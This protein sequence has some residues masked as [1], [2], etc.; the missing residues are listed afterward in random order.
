[1][2]SSSDSSYASNSSST[3]S[4]SLNGN[5][6]KPH[7]ANQAAWQ[8]MNHLRQQHGQVGLDQFRLLY[9]V[10]SGSFGTVYACKIKKPV[11]M[12][13]PDDCIY[14]MKV[15]DTQAQKANAK[16]RVD[17]EKEI[18]R[19]V[20]HPFLPTLYAEFDVSHYSCF[21]MEY[22]PRGDLHH[23]VIN[24]Q[25]AFVFSI[26][27]AK[28]YAAEVLIALEY[29]HAMGIIYRDLK[30]ENVLVQEDGHIMLSD[31]DLSF[32]CDVVP[33][34]LH[35]NLQ[36]EDTDKTMIKSMS[37]FSSILSHKYKE[38]KK[39]KTTQVRLEDSGIEFWAEPITC[40]SSSFVGT[41]EYLAPEMI[42][43]LGYG[44]EV[45]WWAFGVFLYELLYGK[46]PFKGK[47]NK[48]TLKNILKQPLMFPEE[49][50]QY[51]D[52]EMK[53][54]NDL[55]RKLLVKNPKKRMGSFWGAV[56]IKKHVFFRGVEWSLIRS[57]KP[58]I[59]RSR[60]NVTKL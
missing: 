34:L 30:P 9:P 58:P 20:D 28:F 56:E 35:C 57:V 47:N 59:L 53:N 22:C 6:R 32:K 46:T 1:M 43:G 16:N 4:T 3:S 48:T 11:S 51:Y 10:G 40:R 54:A 14:A 41:H 31:F 23:T 24:R 60:E 19:M 15:V 12:E 29:L 42:S 13:F 52:Q 37:F 26:A 8:A 7:K 55:I 50:K 33:K 38:K 17:S 39:K 2:S 25:P 36:P 27:S 44:S 45:D 21:V 18:L 5:T 49:A